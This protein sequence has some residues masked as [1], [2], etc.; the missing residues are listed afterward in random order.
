MKWFIILLSLSILLFMSVFSGKT[1]TEQQVYETVKKFDDFEVRYYPPAIMAKVQTSVKSYREMSSSSFRVLAGYIFGGN[2]ENQK[3][4]MTAPVHVDLDEQGSSMSFVMPAEYEMNSLPKP[5]HPGVTIEKSEPV[6]MAAISFGGY[7]NDD[8]ILN[9][10]EKLKKLLDE[11]GI[12]YTGN[13]RYLGYNS[14]YRII[15]R[16]N[17]VVVQVVWE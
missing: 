16:R 7:A 8:K 9:H 11:N 10:S 1:Q 6:Y 12:K 14:P 15:N 2:S 5:D 4:A 17:D 3:I 13:F